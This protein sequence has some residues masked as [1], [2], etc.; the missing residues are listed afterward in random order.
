MITNFEKITIELTEKE[1]NLVP[2]F[3]AR[4]RNKPGRENIVTNKKMI[5]GIE[6]VH[7][8][9]LSEPRI[10][11]IVQFI[12]INNLLPGLVGV[13][14]GYFLTKDT[15][16]LESWIESMK[17]RENSIRESRIRAENDLDIMKQKKFETQNNEKQS[18]INF[19]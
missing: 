1:E 15:N 9:K 17:Q 2:V 7:G 19:E 18:T 4:F 14:N 8:I 13:S 11:K 3:V 5:A 16:E 10:R 6:K 12:R